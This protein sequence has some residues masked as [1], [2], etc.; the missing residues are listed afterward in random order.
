MLRVW[1]ALKIPRSTGYPRSGQASGIAFL[2]GTFLWRSKEKYLALQGE[3]G[4]KIKVSSEM[5]KQEAKN[6]NL[7]GRNRMLK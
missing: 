4:G 1:R 3:T 7:S 2:L 6:L 5:T